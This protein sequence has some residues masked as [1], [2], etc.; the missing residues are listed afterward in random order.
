MLSRSV[1]IL[2]KT[3]WFFF[4]PFFFVKIKI[5]Q[6]WCN[7]IIFLWLVKYLVCN[8][9]WVF[10]QSHFKLSGP[11]VWSKTVPFSPLCYL[12]VLMSLKKPWNK[13]LLHNSLLRGNFCRNEICIFLCLLCKQ[14]VPW[15]FII[16]S[17]VQVML[18]DVLQSHQA[19]PR[20]CGP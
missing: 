9:R 20:S 5:W 2:F 1:Q 8:Y 13:L 11:L 19:L 4:F 12:T 6:G 18:L 3:F 14:P 17:V 15:H 10:W 7:N 16:T